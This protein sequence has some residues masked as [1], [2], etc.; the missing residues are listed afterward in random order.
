M[1][2]LQVHLIDQYY[3]HCYYGKEDNKPKCYTA[4]RP[5]R[6]V[7]SFTQ[8]M[9]LKKKKNRI[10]YNRERTKQFLRLSHIVFFFRDSKS[11]EKMVYNN[12]GEYNRL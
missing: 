10:Y 4:S 2:Q 8:R 11:Y 6:N 7:F 12:L 3:M 9:K 1:F 5:L